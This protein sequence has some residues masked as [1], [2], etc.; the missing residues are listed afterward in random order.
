MI[1]EVAKFDEDYVDKQASLN[2]M[3]ARMIEAMEN[4]CMSIALVSATE[5]AT[6]TDRKNSAKLEEGNMTEEQVE[7]H[8]IGV[9]CFTIMQVLMLYAAFRMAPNPSTA[10]RYC[11]PAILSAQ[12]PCFASTHQLISIPYHG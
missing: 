6:A 2:V 4:F 3:K 11:N 1:L 7:A 8:V 9:G 5:S 12:T 10:R